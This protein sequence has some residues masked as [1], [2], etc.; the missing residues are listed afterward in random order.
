MLQVQRECQ[1]G[2]HVHSTVVLFI[3]KVT[4]KILKTLM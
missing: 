3:V 2:V 4:G 1:L